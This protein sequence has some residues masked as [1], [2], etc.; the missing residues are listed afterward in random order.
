MS[1]VDVSFK[2]AF[3]P[4]ILKKWPAVSYH[5]PQLRPTVSPQIHLFLRV[6]SVQKRARSGHSYSRIYL[7]HNTQVCQWEKKNTICP[8]RHIVLDPAR[9]GSMLQ[10]SNSRTSAN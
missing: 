4:A 1:A 8:S 2:M 5:H 6:N 7:P 10:P 9:S 3:S